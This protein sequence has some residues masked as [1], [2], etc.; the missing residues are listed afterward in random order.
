[1]ES[2]WEIGTGRGQ[3]VPEKGS[4]MRFLVSLRAFGAYA[5]RLYGRFSGPGVI[6]TGLQNNGAGL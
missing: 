2:Y 1:M 3:D 5:Y 6:A 4:K